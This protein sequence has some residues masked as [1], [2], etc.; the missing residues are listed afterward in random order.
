MSLGGEK[1]EAEI[2]CPTCYLERPLR[3]LGLVRQKAQV[4][5]ETGRITL[6]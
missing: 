6:V 5:V 3:L 2:P 1:Q 4:G